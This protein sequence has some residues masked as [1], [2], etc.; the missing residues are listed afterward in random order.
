MDEITTIK[1]AFEN[2]PVFLPSDEDA[3][4]VQKVLFKSFCTAT[5]SITAL[6]I[7]EKAA[8]EAIK[9]ILPCAAKAGFAGGIF[10]ELLSFFMSLYIVKGQRDKGEIS[11]EQFHHYIMQRLLGGTAAVAGSTVGAIVG[12]FLIPYPVI[13]T[14]VGSLVGGCCADLIGSMI[15]T[16]ISR[17]WF[18]KND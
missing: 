18:K 10:V 9:K 2:V 17:V 4:Y 14:F 8:K 15:A 1:K 5:V 6:K 12:T 16:E 11:D 7:A 13:G 3:K